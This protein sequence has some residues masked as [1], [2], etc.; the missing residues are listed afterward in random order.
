MYFLFACFFLKSILHFLLNKWCIENQYHPIQYEK[1]PQTKRINSKEETVQNITALNAKLAFEKAV[2][3]Y[4]KAAV[5]NPHFLLNYLE[6]AKT[7]DKLGQ[8][9][10]SLLCLNK[11][12]EDNTYTED[13]LFIKKQAEALLQQWQ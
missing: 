13:D 7:Y 9:T 10:K 5:I 12:K 1:K 6:L 4:E 3:A 8:K 11:I 2:Q